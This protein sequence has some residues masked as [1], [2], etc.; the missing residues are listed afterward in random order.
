ME[1]FML[2]LAYAMLFIGASIGRKSDSKIKFLSGNW[3]IIVS[4]LAIAI[5]IIRT[6][7]H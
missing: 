5:Y 2:I 7:P 6:T 1:T 3:L 4:I